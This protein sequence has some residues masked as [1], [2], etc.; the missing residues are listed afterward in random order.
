MVVADSAW[1]VKIE[2]DDR[3][4]N[5]GDHGYDNYNTDMH[6]IFYA[7]G[8]AF[9]NGYLHPTFDNVDL[10]P[11]FAHILNLKPAEVD[12]KLESVKGMLVE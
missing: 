3:G 11:L 12:G 10:Y 7:K 9:K 6:A 2:R 8:P 4:G 5:L 1:R